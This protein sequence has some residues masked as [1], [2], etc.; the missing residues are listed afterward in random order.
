MSHG[1]LLTMGPGHSIGPQTED[2]HGKTQ[3]LCEEE[4]N[5][6][7]Q[8]WVSRGVPRQGEEG[9]GE[10][11]QHQPVLGV[12]EDVSNV[13]DLKRPWDDQQNLTDTHGGGRGAR[14]A[15]GGFGTYSPSTRCWPG[16]QPTGRGH[17]PPCA[18][19]RR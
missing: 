5:N 3:T 4:R 12:N 2:G 16:P 15:L 1:D 6:C 10:P 7:L 8:G 17:C 14:P 19:G 18:P 11:G 13:F 9:C